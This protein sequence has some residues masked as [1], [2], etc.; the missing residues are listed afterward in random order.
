MI[1]LSKRAKFARARARSGR[2]RM[3]QVG[4][5]RDAGFRL[6]AAARLA[7]GIG[8]TKGRHPTD[9]LLRQHAS[10]S[11]FKER[12]FKRVAREWQELR[13][14]KSAPCRHGHSA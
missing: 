4:N 8:E 1:D 13:A 5:F 11:C 6:P 3:V 2:G 7:L 10:C 12:A 14:R 9:I